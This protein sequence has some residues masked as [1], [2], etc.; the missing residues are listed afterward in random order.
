M[1]PA[2]FDEYGQLASERYYFTGTQPA[3]TADSIYT[4][5]TD[6]STADSSLVALGAV[7]GTTSS[8][9]FGGVGSCA[10]ARALLCLGVDYS[11]AIAQPAGVGRL[12]FVGPSVSL[13]GGL[14][15]ADAVCQD[16]ADAAGLTGSFRA[17]LATSSASAASRFDL[18]GSTWVRPDGMPVLSVAADLLTVPPLLAPINVE[19]G[20]EYLGAF[21]SLAGAASASALGTLSETCADWTDTSGGTLARQG[22]AN[23]AD[24]SGFGASLGACAGRR[25]YCLQQ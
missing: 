25:L 19:A 24:S 11:T 22:I 20:G 6:F 4:S 15:E 10:S 21:S 17:L 3:G 2:R 18:S 12:A 13:S 1:S 7:E 8:W 9:T 16:E 14:T 5:C 23:H